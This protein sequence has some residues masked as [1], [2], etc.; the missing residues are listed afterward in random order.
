MILLIKNSQEY[1]FFL[2]NG[3]YIIQILSLS[4]LNDVSNYP[5]EV[6]VIKV[7]LWSISKISVACFVFKLYFEILTDYIYFF[8]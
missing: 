3:Q 1:Q 7:K 5:I 2:K 6:K 4:V 8:I